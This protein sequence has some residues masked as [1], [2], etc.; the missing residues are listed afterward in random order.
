MQ[1]DRELAASNAFFATSNDWGPLALGLMK[2]GTLRRIA[3]QW[4][5]DQWAPALSLYRQAAG[6]AHRAGSVAYQA[7]ALAW[8]SSVEISMN[9]I[10]QASS[11]AKEALRLAE[12][13]GDN[14]VLAHALEA[15]GAVQIAQRDL[16]G[17]AAT[18][19]RGVS[20][21]SKAKDPM[22]TYFAFSNRAD[23]YLKRAERCSFERAFEP[24]YQALDHARSDYQRALTIARKSGYTALATGTQQFLSY[25]E[26][27]RALLQ[28]LDRQ[29]TSLLDADKFRPKMPGDVLVTDTFA[30]HWEGMPPPA[31]MQL[32][33]QVKRL[34]ASGYAD[35]SSA[36]GRYVEGMVEE[37]QGNNDEALKQ[38]LQAAELLQRDRRALH[39]ERSRGTIL[40][41]RIEIYYAAMLRLL[42]R[43]RYD[44]AF[45]L[46]ENSRSRA[47]AD[48]L[49]TRKLGLGRPREQALYAEWMTLRSS[50]ADAQDELFGLAAAVDPTR[51]DSQIRSLQARIRHLENNEA[52]L[53]LRIDTEAPQ[54]RNLA[55]PEPV[56]LKDLQKSMREEGYEMLQY[57]VLEHGIV[58]WHITPESVFVRNVFLPRSELIH[59]VELLNGSLSNSRE[60]KTSS[61]VPTARELFLYLVQPIIG[62]VH[63]K[64]LVIVP[65]ETL[66][67]I[68]FQAL[69]NPSDGSYLGE[70]LQI[71]YAL[72]AS[73]LLGLRRPKGIIGG[74]L[75]AVADPS[76][77]NFAAEALRIAKLFPGRSKVS[78]NPLATKSQVKSWIG[79]FDIVHFSVHGK[80]VAGEPLLSYLALA[81]SGADN[82]Q[83]TAAEMFG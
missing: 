50:I 60:P 30:P 56:T 32:Y 58:L 65:H 3:A 35:A 83:L 70:H 74:R 46:L 27:R 63:A 37:M 40:E 7:D 80:Y 75:L 49:A 2:Q 42:D 8:V 82:G 64:R 11:D 4:A 1:A 43:H 33:Q 48:L 45:R 36:R 77:Q 71:S 38:F 19:E 59:K 81:P 25:V 39:D 67:T 76:D 51:N 31:L 53:R 20:I 22:A 62:E 24:C 47:M 13:A 54:L 14:N 66:G 12:T 34:E 10:A 16:S 5:P 28:Q 79:N 17:A 9:N 69:Q 78:I 72:S 21:A 44:E 52:I 57:V 6:A 15:V 55:A 68:P 61:D 26:T 73:V 23:M 18:F 29:H 41:D